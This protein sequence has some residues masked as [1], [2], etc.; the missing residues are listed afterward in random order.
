LF[1]PGTADLAVARQMRVVEDEL[2]TIRGLAVLAR[3][4][5]RRW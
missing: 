2:D 4:R 1:P 3:G 5:T